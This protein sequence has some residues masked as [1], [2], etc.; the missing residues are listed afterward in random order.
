MKLAAATERLTPIDGGIMT[1]A[2]ALS[3]V[4]SVGFDALI[5]TA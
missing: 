5:L 4:L 3:V 2:F 1:V